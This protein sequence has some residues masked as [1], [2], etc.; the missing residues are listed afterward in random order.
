MQRVPSEGLEEKYLGEASRPVDTALG[1]VG[2][3]LEF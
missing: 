1:L 2:V 3:M